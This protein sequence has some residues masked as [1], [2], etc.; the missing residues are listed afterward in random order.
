MYTLEELQSKIN[1][2]LAKE[3]LNED[4]TKAFFKLLRSICDEVLMPTE[5]IK[6][7]TPVPNDLD[8]LI[9]KKMKE[10]KVQ[11]ETKLSVSWFLENGF[12]DVLD[13]SGDYHSV[14]KELLSHS[15]ILKEH[16]K[17]LDWI[18]VEVD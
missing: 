11:N 3:K 2:V 14:R 13:A 1:K 8:E 16:P 12:A 6:V 7:R 18:L 9:K 15:K 5:E 10:D 4:Q 17:S